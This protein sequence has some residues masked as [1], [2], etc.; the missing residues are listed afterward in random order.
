MQR[1]LTWKSL[2][3]VSRVWTTLCFDLKVYG[4]HHLPQTGPALVLSNHQSLLDMIA[5][6]VQLDRPMSYMAR[7]DLFDH[8]GLARL[9]RKLHAFP[10][11]QE[12][13]DIGAIKEAVRRLQEG[14]IV[15]IYPEGS[16]TLTGE[17][18]PME[19][20]AALIVRRAKVPVVPAVVWGAFEAWPRDRRIFRPHPIR[21]QFGPPMMLHHLRGE[22]VM[23]Q[24]EQ[25]LKAMYG[26]LRQQCV[27]EL[28]Q[29]RM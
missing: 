6:A 8:A 2:Q 7:H 3:A 23:Q 17:I 27:E 22:Q 11:R 24:V 29:Q 5:L 16:R 4:Q 18:G 26:R 13:A 25:T 19:P 21:V 28:R 1:S 14:H 12:T 9:I 10:V 20:G 15:N